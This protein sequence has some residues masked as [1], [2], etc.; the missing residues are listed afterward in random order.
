[1]YLNIILIFFLQIYLGERCMHKGTVAHELM[2]A[3]GF[4]HE[5]SRPDRDQYIKIFWS[6]IRRGWFSNLTKT[7]K[8][9]HEFH[10]QKTAGMHVNFAK[11]NKNHWYAYDSNYDVDSVMHYSSKQAGTR[12]GGPTIKT[13]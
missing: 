12:K 7:N 2:H 4:D 3:L 13:K 6:N 5:Q 11:K 1:M 8:T 9:L 10:E